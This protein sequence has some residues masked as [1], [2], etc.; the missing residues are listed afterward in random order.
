MTYQHVK[1][2]YYIKGRTKIWVRSGWEKNYCRYL[3]WLK[4]LGEIVDWAYEAFE[5]W[6]P[7]LRGTRSYKPD[8]K[9]TNND[10][11]IEWHEVKGYWTRK[12]K[13]QVSRFRKYYPDLK[14]I[15]IDKEAYKAIAEKSALIP[16]WE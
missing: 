4:D 3:D 15:V 5:F 12:A 6:F 10:G 14:L 8:F 11:S 2:G 16:G 1:A 9:I 7:V 13:T